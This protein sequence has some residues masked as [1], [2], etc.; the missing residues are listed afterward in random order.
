[1]R[2]TAFITA[3]L[4]SSLMASTASADQYLGNLSNNPYDSNSTA[5]PYGAGSPYS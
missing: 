3:L 4:L 2:Y 1:M 5:N